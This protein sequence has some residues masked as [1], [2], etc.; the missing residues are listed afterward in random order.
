MSE[1]GDPGTPAALG[2]DRSLDASGL[3]LAAVLSRER[4]DAIVPAAWQSRALLPGAVSVFVICSGGASFHWAARR[5]RPVS[6]HPLDDF[7]E[8]LVRRAA[9]GLEGAGYATR[10]VFYWQR[11]GANDL[12]S[13]QF[14]DFV[15]LA[16]AAGLGA[17]S[18]L[19]LLLHARFGPWFAIRALL[20]SECPAPE[21]ARTDDA[22]DPCPS[23][24]APCIAACRGR[25]VSREKFS[26]ERCAQTRKESAE[27]AQRCDARLACPLGADYRYDRHALSHHMTSRFRGAGV[28]TGFPSG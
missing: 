14:A 5:A 18:Q 19:G 7:C 21:S 23:C 27:C 28:R 12:E 20:L 13:G 17:T 26:S 3:N 24:S 25:A 22:F 1:P 11:R 6:Q 2:L 9:S 10:A 16:R 4:Y 8:A 15:G